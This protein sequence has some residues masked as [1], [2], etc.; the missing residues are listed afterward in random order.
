[1]K[2][3]LDIET[4]ICFPLI[5][6]EP[7]YDSLGLGKI[8]SSPP[9]SFYCIRPSTIE[10]YQNVFKHYHNVEQKYLKLGKQL[11]MVIFL[12]SLGELTKRSGFILTDASKK[13]PTHEQLAALYY[14]FDDLHYATEVLHKTYVERGHK[15]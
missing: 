12:D 10:C 9:T 14:W 13:S 6:H 11:W 3:T 7:H 4:S 1:M 8:Y 15:L 5:E 2:N